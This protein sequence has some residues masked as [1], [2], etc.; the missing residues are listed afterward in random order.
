MARNYVVRGAAG[1]GRENRWEA[2]SERT[3]LVQEAAQENQAREARDQR[4]LFAAAAQRFSS[5]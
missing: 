4:A 3:R 5:R 2:R 1:R